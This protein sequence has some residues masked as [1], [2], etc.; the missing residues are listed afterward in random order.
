[1]I[2]LG[3]PSLTI[4]TLGF[5]QRSRR[6]HKTMDLEDVGK[7]NSKKN[8]QSSVFLGELGRRAPVDERIKGGHRKDDQRIDGF[9]GIGGY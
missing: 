8:S 3:T 2:Q 6:R 5:K 9:K 7:S 1:M 4:A